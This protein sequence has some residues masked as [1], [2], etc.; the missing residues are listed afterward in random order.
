M[1]TTDASLPSMWSLQSMTMTCATRVPSPFQEKRR[2]VPGRSI[3]D[4]QRDRQHSSFRSLR[5]RRS[6]SCFLLLRFL[7]RQSGPFVCFGPSRRFPASAVPRSPSIRVHILSPWR[8]SVSIRRRSHASHDLLSSVPTPRAAAFTYVLHRDP[9]R[10]AAHVSTDARPRVSQGRCAATRSERPAEFLQGRWSM[11][12]IASGRDTGKGGNPDRRRSRNLS[13]SNGNGRW[14][15]KRRR[16]LVWN[17][18]EMVRTRRGS[19]GWSGPEGRQ[20]LD[21]SCRTQ[22]ERRVG[23]PFSCGK[24]NVR[25]R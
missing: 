8:F 16:S 17:G 23:I 24:G 25:S 19:R 4:R 7:D 20:S 2:V 1:A 6:A 5:T 12:D 9:R 15:S 10:T 13:S 11:G 18:V 22:E 3:G 21:P 14:R